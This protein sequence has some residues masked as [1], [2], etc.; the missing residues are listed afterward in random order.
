MTDVLTH[1]DAIRAAFGT[2]DGLA[3]LDIGCGESRLPRDLAALGAHCTGID[4]FMPARDWEA[5]G[6]G[7]WRILRTS[8]EALPLPDASID[9][10]LFIYSLHHVPAAARAA[11]F[12]ETRR[13][14]KP[15]GRL[16]VAEPLASGDFD[17][18]IN[19]F[20]DE[21]RVRSEAQSA[22]ATARLSFERHA[23]SAYVDRRRYDSFEAFATMMQANTRFNDY[24]AADVV[25]P[26]VRDRF[27]TIAAR[28]GGVFDQPVKVD[29]LG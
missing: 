24:T 16:Y 20:H 7:R 22:L 5:E 13:V 29:I 1:L 6:A 19:V 28:T 8:A 9:G 10:I 4:P 11:A 21:S 23:S 18:V 15:D 14:L 25:A 17:D 2:V 3:L 27:E 26:A 12:R